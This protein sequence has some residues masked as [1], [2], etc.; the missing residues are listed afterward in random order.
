VGVSAQDAGEAATAC[1]GYFSDL[2]GTR[3][4]GKV[5]CRLDGVL[6]LA[7]LATLAGAEAFS[8]IARFG[9][10]K[11]ALPR[12]FRPFKDATPPHDRIGDIFA[13]LDA[14]RFQRVSSPGSPR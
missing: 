11:L 13:S 3:Q 7:L 6:L 1:L 5:M 9:E 4:A 10:K 14:G 2:T 12:R 8:D